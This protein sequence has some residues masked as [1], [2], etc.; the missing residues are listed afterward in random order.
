MNEPE[1]KMGIKGSDTRQIFFNDCYVPV[2][3]MLSDRGNGFKIAVNILNIGR[4]KLAV[5]AVGGAKQVATQA[6]QYANERKQFGIAISTF[7]A[8]KHKL[9]EM[10]VKLYASE[11][12]S[13]RLVRTLTMPSLI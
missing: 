4:I 5:A 9:A 13:Y 6:I 11:S 3:N 7:G 2:E 10:A 8:I 12:A 1:H